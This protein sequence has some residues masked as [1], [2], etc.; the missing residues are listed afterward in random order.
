M[1]AV[2]EVLCLSQNLLSRSC[3]FRSSLRGPKKCSAKVTNI[4]NRSVLNRLVF[5]KQTN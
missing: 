2:L 1:T 4:Q 5:F 3:C